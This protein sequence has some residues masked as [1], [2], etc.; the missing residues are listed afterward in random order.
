[1]KDEF[2]DTC[3]ANKIFETLS[4]AFLAGSADSRIALCGALPVLTT[5]DTQA[6][7]CG[8]Q[9]RRSVDFMLNMPSSLRAHA[10]HGLGQL[11]S[12]IVDRCASVIVWV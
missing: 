4:T 8:S 10:M 5:W 9:V 12:V 11:A 1:M 2:P 7:C 3:D 6:F